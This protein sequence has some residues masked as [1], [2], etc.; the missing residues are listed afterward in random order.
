MRIYGSGY[1]GSASRSFSVEYKAPLR[2]G[3]G[4]GGGFHNYLINTTDFQLLIRI[5]T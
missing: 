5:I 4:G 3:A 2:G 1:N